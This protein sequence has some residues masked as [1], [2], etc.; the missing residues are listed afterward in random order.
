MPRPDP[1]GVLAERMA[2]LSVD[3]F[4]HEYH[5]VRP[6]H[7]AGTAGRYDDLFYWDVLNRLLRH[8]TDGSWGTEYRA[9]RD[10]EEIDYS[11]LM[12]EGAFHPPYFFNL[13]QS[14][15]SLIF[16][17]LQSRHDPLFALAEACDELFGTET[18]ISVT[19]GGVRSSHR[20]PMH[21][22]FKDVLTFQVAGRR[23]WTLRPPTR[24]H[25]VA[26]VHTRH[27]E[28]IQRIDRERAAGTAD[29]EEL[30]ELE[31]LRENVFW[32]GELAPGHAL[33]VPRG[34]YHEVAPLGEPELSVT[35]HQETVTGADFLRDLIARAEAT[36][37]LLR[38]GLPLTG[39]GDEQAAFLAELRREL[40]G[41]LEQATVE[42]FRRRVRSRT[43][44]R[45]LGFSFPYCLQA[46]WVPDDPALPLRWQVG[47]RVNL[48]P[49]P[50]QDE[51]VVQALGEEWEFAGDVECAR[52]ILE[53]L[54]DRGA[55]ALGEV[56]ALECVRGRERGE[57]RAFLQSL[58][59]SGLLGVGPA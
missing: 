45:A 17:G 54:R 18:L 22:D 6:V 30:G 51:L 16:T 40:A 35:C 7:V 32:E 19:A 37:P 28:E 9:Y 15:L 53:H 36:R 14:G 31:R 58:V 34:W 41:E 26:G 10:G 50:E 52:G 55:C 57:I 39:T 42:G 1:R 13:L 29:P 56:Y 21:F 59:E 49:R 24:E 44:P 4:L 11:L 48:V 33:Y 3:V 5:G 20:L 47:P 2:P 43:R 46:E 38:R 27:L 8:H 25:P 12:R 23:R